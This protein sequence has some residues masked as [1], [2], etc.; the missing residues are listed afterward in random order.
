MQ[1]RDATLVPGCWRLALLSCVLVLLMILLPVNGETRAR[2]R[3]HAAA[4]LL[5]TFRIVH[6]WRSRVFQPS[7]AKRT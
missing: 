3:T 4:E 2:A 5:F 6:I 1:R 7:N